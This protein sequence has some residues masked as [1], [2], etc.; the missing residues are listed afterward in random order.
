MTLNKFLSLLLQ[1]LTGRTQGMLHEAALTLSYNWVHSEAVTHK[2]HTQ[3]KLCVFLCMKVGYA[4]SQ[5]KRQK[6]WFQ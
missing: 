1:I 2:T 3:K 6:P 5:S 4:A